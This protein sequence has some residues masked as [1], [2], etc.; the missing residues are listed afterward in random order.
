M[1]LLVPAGRLVLV[2]GRWSTGAGLDADQAR[3]LVEPVARVSEVRAL[4]DP[5]YWGKDIDDQR[6]L[7]VAH[8]RPSAS[9]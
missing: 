6:Y 7:L 3:M 9:S 2:E 8:L 1:D 4:V 5:A